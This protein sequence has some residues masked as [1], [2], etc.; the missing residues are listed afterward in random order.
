M[1]KIIQGLRESML[2]RT[3]QIL[4][5]GGYGEVTIRRVARDCGVAVGTVYNYYPSKE[6]LVAAV[7]L[8]DW[9]A[10][11]ERMDAAAQGATGLD[12]GVRG[13]YEALCGFTRTFAPAWGEYTGSGGDLSAFRERHLQLVEQITGQLEI[14]T[15]RLR[16]TCPLICLQTAA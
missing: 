2:G 1:P 4:L 15:G 5:E 13:M 12:G 8:Q 10:V 16:L 14:M 3:R 9:Q 7:M 11:R 6:M